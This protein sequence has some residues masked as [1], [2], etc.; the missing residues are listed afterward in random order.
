MT[1]YRAY[2]HASVEIGQ[3]EKSGEVSDISIFGERLSDFLLK[4][5]LSLGVLEQEVQG[6]GDCSRSGLRASDNG[7]EAF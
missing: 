5:Q 4:T 7:N 6:V 2:L 1:G 3:L